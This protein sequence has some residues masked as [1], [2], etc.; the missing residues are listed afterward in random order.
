MAKDFDITKKGYAKARYNDSHVAEL[1]KCMIDPLYFAE[2]YIMIQHPIFGRIPFVPYPFQR[3]I[4]K[5]FH[6]NR[7]CIA[8]TSRQ[9]GKCCSFATLITKNTGQIQIGKLFKFNL[10]E[11]IINYLENIL[12]KI[13]AD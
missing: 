12:I 9:S 10:R 7:N 11:K 3:R 2:K 8:M 5:A 13:V 6:D 1:A 4:I